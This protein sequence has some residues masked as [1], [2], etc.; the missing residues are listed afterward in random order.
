MARLFID[1]ATR[2]A[3]AARLTKSKIGALC[4]YKANTAEFLSYDKAG[5]LLLAEGTTVVV[6]GTIFVVDKDTQIDAAACLDVSGASLAYGQDYYVYMCDTAV[7]DDDFIIKVSLSSTYPQGFKA[8]T[9]RKIGGF[10]YGSARGISYNLKPT[11]TAGT[12]YGTGWEG[13]VKTDIVPRSVW[14]LTHR[15]KC[16]PEG[17]VYIGGGVWADIYEE[18]SDG[19]G[20]LVSKCGATP[21]TGSEHINWYVFNEMCL[22]CDKRL[23]SYDEWMKLAF[24]SPA[25]TASGN[26]NGWVNQTSRNTTGQI[27][28]ATSSIGCRDCVGNVREW[29]DEIVINPGDSSTPAYN[30]YDVFTTDW[31]TGFGKAY[32]PNETGIACPTCG[33]GFSDGLYSGERSTFLKDWPWKQAANI[34]ARLVCDSE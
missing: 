22:V 12:E 25:G 1:D 21:V 29:T 4:D 19:A 23:P 14:C 15:P 13:N 6:N 30:W 27:T 33:G 28:N 31:N 7:N 5:K 24:G 32:M 8:S 2:T 16:S 18:S 3:E 20:G 10:H 11:N 26:T 34:G 17:M 9:S